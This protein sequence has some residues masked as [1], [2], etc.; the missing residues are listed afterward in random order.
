MRALVRSLDCGIWKPESCPTLLPQTGLR[1]LGAARGCQGPA[2]L[3]KASWGSGSPR[4]KAGWPSS[5]G[6]TGLSVRPR[7][8]GADAA[9]PEQV[10]TQ[11]QGAVS[12]VTTEAEAGV[13]P[14][15]AG[16]HQGCRQP[17]ELGEVGGPSPGG[18]SVGEGVGSLALATSES[19][20]SGFQT[21]RRWISVLL[22][23]QVCVQSFRP[24]WKQIHLSSRVLS[25]PTWPAPPSLWCPPCG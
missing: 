23:P 24:P 20:T 15:Q 17:Q 22:G 12:R 6:V 13:M 8:V 1:S 16:E 3:L 5:R 25:L 18:G 11:L 7:G 19:L 21:L 10:E 14:E 2:G 9:R 4:S